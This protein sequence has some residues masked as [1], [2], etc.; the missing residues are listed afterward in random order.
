M[1]PIVVPPTTIRRTLLG[2]T[3]LFL[4]V[5]ATAILTLAAQS[6]PLLTTAVPGSL[7]DG[8]TLL[9]NGW[10]LAPAGRH[11]PV[12]TLPLNFVLSPDGRYAVVTNNG[13]NKPSLTVI[14]VANWSVKATA[15]VDHAWYGLAWHPDGTKLYSSG[16]A[17]NT[18]REF[19]VA[20]GVITTE[21]TFALPAGSGDMFAGGIAV[22]RDGR[23]LFVTRVFAMTL[24][25][26]DLTTGLVTKTVQLPS[27]PYTAV[28]SPDGQLV[29]V[30]LW[31][32]SAV[33]V[34]TAESL[35]RVNEMITGDH[36]N[37]MALSA[38]AKRLFVACGSSAAVWVFDTFSGEAIEQVSTNLFAEAPPTSTPNSV[39]ISPDGRSLLVANADINAVAVV[40]ISNGARSFL[41][42]FIPVGWYPTGAMFSRDGKQ[43]LVLNGKGLM[44]VAPNPLTGGMEKRLLG[45]VSILPTP[46]RTTLLEFSRKVFTLS[47]SYT[48]TTLLSPVG[49]PVGSPIPRVVGG[50][51]PIKHVFYVIRENR[52]YDQILGDLPEGNGDPRLALFGKDITPNAHEL[53][54]NFVL[55]DNF[56][57]DADVSYNGHSY[58]TA[59]Y[60]T[61]FIEKMWQTSMVGRGVPYLAEGGGFMRSPF[62]NI[63]SPTLGYLW[64]YARRAKVSVRSYGEFVH[65]VKLPNGEVTAVEAVPGLKGAVAPAFAGW[66]L[67]ITDVKRVD[68]WLQEFREYEANGTL[69][70]LSIIRLP[71]DH[72]AGTRAG[73]PTPRAM[74][75]DNDLALGR[76]IEAVSTSVY[77]KDSAFFVLEDDAQSGPDHVDSH[78]SVLLVASPFAKRGVVDH[79][80]YTTSG[81]LRTIE[82]ILGLGPMSQYD[83]AATPLFNAFSGTPNLVA[84]GRLQP[85]VPLDERNVASAFG[86]ALSLAMDFSIEDRAPE[87]LLN[88]IVWRSIRGAHSPMPPPRR[89]IFVRPSSGA[90]DD[91]D[92]HEP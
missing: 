15:V 27:E 60:A 89:S 44:P 86:S 51:S 46:D 81:V 48:N 59:A 7:S 49:V 14:D 79:T 88:D 43:I 5:V 30:S 66:D 25:A 35:M 19:S 41:D 91:D 78:R 73:S 4:A 39:A 72:T 47:P 84:F 52:T 11:L 36:P 42:G 55:F 61:D 1:I 69:P 83:A 87:M 76:M 40:D 20:D 17:Q 26:I 29:Y 16:A 22:S 82:L 68:S 54:K 31:G 37:A 67:D 24:S 38:D 18:V 50:S 34:Y 32:G 10:R 57:V 8:T 77:W 6:A 63:S 45:A 2:F 70:Q 65:H 85:H 80:F 75:A 9:A 71:N 62:G 13:V 12:G 58:S 64:D 56:Y 33:Q 3:A 90:L 74:M 53:A 21:R 92:E 28:V 23:R